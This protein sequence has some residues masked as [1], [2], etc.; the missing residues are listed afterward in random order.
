MTSRPAAPRVARVLAYLAGAGL[1][2]FTFGVLLALNA[3]DPVLML[4]TVTPFALAAAGFASFWPED[5]WRWGLR[6]SA[7][8]VLFLAWTSMAFWL[9]SRID[10]VPMG[11]ALVVALAACL[12]AALAGRLRRATPSGTRHDF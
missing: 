3:D 2:A 6:V 5:S 11:R 7:A 12:A 1:L 9:N 4:V 10:L 8:I